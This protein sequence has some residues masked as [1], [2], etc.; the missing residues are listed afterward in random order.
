MVRRSA[1]QAAPGSP[2]TPSPRS[3][4]PCGTS[5]PG[6]WTP[7]ARLLG[8][9]T[10][11]SGLRQRRVHQL[12][13][14]R[15][16]AQLARWV[17]S[18][19]PARKIKIGGVGPHPERDLERMTGA[20][21]EVGDPTPRST[22]TPT[23]ARPRKQAVRLAPDF[24][25]A[26]ASPGSRSR[27][28]PTTSRAFARSATLVEADVAAGEYGYDLTYFGDV[29]AGAVDCLQADVTRCGGITDGCGR[30]RR[31]RPPPRDLRALRPAP[32]AP[33]AAA[34]PNLRHLE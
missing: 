30:R 14:D 29:A 4:S 18:R 7:S 25:D 27:C 15:L 9:R 5:R 28:P 1:T 22:S 12:R 11:R 2:A 32:H 10:T 3:T 8:A 21:G 16:T 31:R 13:D 6:C 33:L 17:A 26:S 23:A 20:R 34:A 24:A 19:D